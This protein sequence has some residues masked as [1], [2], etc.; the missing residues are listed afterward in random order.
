MIFFFDCSVPMV[1]QQLLV[2]QGVEQI[3]TVQQILHP[4]QRM[5]G[6]MKMDWKG[7]MKMDWKNQMELE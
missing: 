6:S 1:L 3:K 5:I 2:W 4:I 7:L